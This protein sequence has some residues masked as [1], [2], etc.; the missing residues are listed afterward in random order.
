MKSR[1]LGIL[2]VGSLVA[3][4]AVLA[5]PVTPSPAGASPTGEIHTGW[6]R[7]SGSDDHGDVTWW[8]VKGRCTP[9]YVAQRLLCAAISV[10]TEAT[11]RGFEAKVSADTGLPLPEGWVLTTAKNSPQI[12]SVYA[13]T[14][15]DLAAV[16]DFYRDA[17]GKRGW[18]EN[19]G[20]VV[21]PDRAVITFTTAA[22][23]VLLRLSRQN[24]KTVAE[25][26]RR[27]F[28][29]AT[30]GLLPKP[31]Q[32]RLLLGNKTDEAAVITV[33]EQAI[34]LAAHAGE[35]LTD[36][37][38][39]AGELP[40]GQ[41]I[42]LPPGKYEVTLKVEGGKVQSREFEV[43]ASETWGLLVGT[44]GALLPMRLY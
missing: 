24:D 41:R 1:T 3:A 19:D 6:T 18:A 10:L 39:A 2:L 44:D 27:K 17:L 15:R 30:A 21:A 11:S 5:I 34:R 9:E 31:G 32:V 13:E 42:D 14:P 40:D 43:A 26:S 33:A 36:S 8:A 16:L 7:T 20:A 25:L 22:R 37:D 38:A 4:T 35:K 23:P 28:A 12:N 29:P